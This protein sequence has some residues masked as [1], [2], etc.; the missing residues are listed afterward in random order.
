MMVLYRYQNEINSCPNKVVLVLKTKFENSHLN[1]FVSQVS[2]TLTEV[3]LIDSIR[4]LL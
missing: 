1:L 4:K 3:L 2:E